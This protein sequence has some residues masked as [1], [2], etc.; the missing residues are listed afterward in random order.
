MFGMRVFC[1]THLIPD[2]FSCHMLRILAIDVCRFGG[3]CCLPAPAHQL[4]SSN[5]F[6]LSAPEE[7]YSRSV[8]A[9]GTLKFGCEGVFKILSAWLIHGISYP[10][11]VWKVTLATVSSQL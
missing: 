6:H 7:A 3:V 1:C 4:F 8:R 9:S 10:L 11:R 5:S 2:V